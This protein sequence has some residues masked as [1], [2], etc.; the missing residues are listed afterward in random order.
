[1]SYIINLAIFCC[2]FV[3]LSASLNL[4]MGSTG[5]FNLGHIAFYAIGAYTSALMVKAGVPFIV[6]LFAAAA[7]AGLSSLVL[8]IPS[9][10]LKGHYFAIATFGFGEIAQAVVKNWSA[11]TR[12]PMGI[13]AIPKPEIFGFVFYEPVQI[14]ALYLVITIIS[15]IIIHKLVNSPFGRVLRGLREDEI[16]SKSLGKDTTFYKMQAVFIG[17]LFA[18]IAG[19]MYAHYILF[20]D[21]AMFGLQHIVTVF[22]MVVVGGMGSVG[23]SV[24]GAIIIF[25]IPEPLRFLQLP[26]TVVASLRLVIYSLLII[27]MTIFMPDGIIKE[28][29]FKVK[30]KCS[31]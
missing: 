16:A 21:P 24:L 25:L 22:A 17:A 11:F 9:M 13:P 31:A 8:S 29:N 14:L 28:K 20:I 10:R 15:V 1:M 4:T 19:N 18:G 23:G 26:G 2:V 7:V 12:G 30:K 27:L 3:I 5:L 6:A